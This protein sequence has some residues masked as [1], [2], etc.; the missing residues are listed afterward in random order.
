[1]KKVFILFQMKNILLNFKNREEFL[2]AYKEEFR[3]TKR[4]SNGYSDTNQT[5]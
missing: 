1:M 4:K 2:A 5:I 3:K